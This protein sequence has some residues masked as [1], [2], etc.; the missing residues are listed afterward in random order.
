MKTCPRT[1]RRMVLTGMKTCPRT[2]RIMV[3][4][5]S[6]APTPSPEAAPDPT[7]P[8]KCSEPMLLAN[9]DAPTKIALLS[10]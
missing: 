2:W 9:T 3:A 6:K 8:M 5:S 1:W 7:S 10:C 4:F